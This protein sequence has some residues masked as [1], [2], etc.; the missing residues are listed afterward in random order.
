MAL[1][2]PEALTIARQMDAKIKGETITQLHL[3]DT[4]TSL[5]RQGFIN[6]HQVDLDNH[7]VAS[8]TSQGKW[9]FVNLEP[10]FYL[11][12]AL[13]TGGKLLYHFPDLSSLQGKYHVKVNFS[14]GSSVTEAITGWGWAKAFNAHDLA[15]QRYR[16]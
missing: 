4:C 15:F 14:D 11:L 12:F 7:I 10:E 1:E 8:V 9:V 6:L 2:L 13:E 5:I 3:S 16:K